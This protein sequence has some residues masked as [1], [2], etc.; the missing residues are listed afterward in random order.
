ML[1]DEFYDKLSVRAKK[2]L[3][4]RQVNSFRELAKMNEYELGLIPGCGEGTARE[5]AGAFRADGR[6]FDSD[7]CQP[8]PQKEQDLQE[9]LTA[10]TEAIREARELREYF[11]RVRLVL[12]IRDLFAAAALHARLMEYWGNPDDAAGYETM[13]RDACDIADAMMAARSKKQGC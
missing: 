2:A 6:E 4:R 3:T 11:E 1:W 7:L 8:E 12:P 5:I 13:C 10:A 9:F